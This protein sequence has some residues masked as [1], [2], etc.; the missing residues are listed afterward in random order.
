MTTRGTQLQTG[1]RPAELIEADLSE[2]LPA[3]TDQEA[4]AEASRC[5]YCFDAPCM[6]A[7]PTSIDI[8]GF[9]KLIGTDDRLGSAQRILGQN[10][11]GASC[12][13][14]CAVE[15]LC[16]EACVLAPHEGPI[17]IGRLQRYGTDEVYGDPKGFAR[18]GIY[19]G[20]ATGKSVAVVGG[21]PAGLAAAAQ[22]RIEGHAVT[23]FE[24]QPELG[25]LAMYGII[26]LREPSDVALWEASQVVALGATARTG[27]EVGVDVAA[28]ELVKDFDAIFLANGSGARVSDIGLEGDDLPG[29]EDALEFIERIR[30]EKPS[31]VPVGEHVVIVG[32]GN[33]AMDAATIAA[34]L[35]AVSV[36]CVYRR[37]VREMTGYPNE[38]EH[39]LKDGVRFAWLMQP[40][41]AI[42][43]P[44]GHV[45]QLEC[46]VVALGE[47]GED[48]RPAPFVTDDLVVVPCDH[49]LLATGQRR[50]TDLYQQLGLNVM[51]DRPVAPGPYRTTDPMVFAGGDAVLSGK[52]LSVV[53]AVAQGREAARAIDAY[54]ME[55]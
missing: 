31:Q 20:V 22:L 46:R 5:L 29:V 32:A 55:D 34:R 40:V 2:R 23:I 52:E 35:G 17:K 39:C 3:M 51:W 36:T 25:G 38:Y 13:R 44:D 15:E 8:P 16:E 21:G 28:D 19:P 42:A 7:C 49:V 47:P 11:M 6:V 54:L 53:D 33:T 50:E 14:V 12:A 24:R 37:T 1:R 30:V 9:I 43:G 18:A 41:R 45:A 10:V 27:V 26:P 48:G 4:Y